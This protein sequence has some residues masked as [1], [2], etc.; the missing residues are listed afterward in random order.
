[1]KRKSLNERIRERCEQRGL[2]FKPWETEPWDVDDGPSPYPKGTSGYET[3]GP[4]Q[5]LRRRLIAEIRARK[6]GDDVA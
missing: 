2:K 4:A 5:A 6:D 3:W 1:M